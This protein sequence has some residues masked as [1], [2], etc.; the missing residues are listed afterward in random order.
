MYH[1]YSHI[2]NYD[3]TILFDFLNG[4]SNVCLSCLFCFRFSDL[5]MGGGSYRSKAVSLHTGN[6]IQVVISTF[7]LFRSPINSFNS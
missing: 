7:P 1:M 2:Q 5:E 4:S 3:T 6:A